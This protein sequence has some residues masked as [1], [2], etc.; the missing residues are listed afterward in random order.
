MTEMSPTLETLKS[1]WDK[2]IPALR[3]ELGKA[4][5]VA[6][7]KYSESEVLNAAYAWGMRDFGENRV[8]DLL[9]KGRA[10]QHCSEVRWHFIGHLQKN[11]VRDLIKI[12]GLYAIHSVDSL[13]LLEK[14][15]LELSKRPPGQGPLQLYF[16]INTSGEAEKGG[17]GHLQAVK[18]MAMHFLKKVDPAQ[19]QW[20]GLMTMATHRTNDKMG[21]AKRC[22]Q[23]LKS[24][25][26]ELDV[27]ASQINAVGGLGL[28][29]ARPL[30][31]SMGMSDDYPLAIREGSTVV[32][33][34]SKIFRP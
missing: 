3:Q 24:M 28:A 20:A 5:F 25:A 15:I 22:F 27:W 18:E 16:E 32:R 17:V 1:H 10:L 9:L 19:A 8:Q 34:G 31:L 11:K 6:V 12:P 14:I 33:I 26:Q 29:M 13:A 4:I 21:E 7:T 23:Q 2:T 30:G